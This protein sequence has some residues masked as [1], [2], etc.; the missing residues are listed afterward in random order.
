MEAVKIK[1]I[2]VIAH[3]RDAFPYFVYKGV[4]NLVIVMFDLSG[5]KRKSSRLGVHVYLPY[6]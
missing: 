4:R 1:D 5:R 6:R 3:S 2:S